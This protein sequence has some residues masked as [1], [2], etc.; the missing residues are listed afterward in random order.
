MVNRKE[1]IENCIRETPDVELLNINMDDHTVTGRLSIKL[2]VM[3]SPLS[4][5]FSIAFTYPF[6][7]HETESILFFNSDL[8]EYSHVMRNG[9]IC[10]HTTSNPDLKDKLNIDLASLK[11]WIL[12]YY[13]NKDKDDHYEHLVV[14]ENPLKGKLQTFIFT[15]CEVPFKPGD[16]GFVNL[17]LI[18][19]G[20]L[21]KVND[22]N[23]VINHL[24]KEF[25]SYDK[26]IR[27]CQWSTIYQHEKATEGGFYCFS[28]QPPSEYQRFIVS[29]WQQLSSILPLELLNQLHKMEK[30]LLKNKQKGIIPLF[31]GY[32][33]NND[34][35]HWQIALFQVGNFPFVGEPEY[36]NEKKTG[37]WNTKILDSPID[38]GIAR[39]SS[40]EYFFG[41]GR[42]CEK[43]TESK[44]L[45]I[46]I[47]AVGS[48]HARTLVRC[49]C[50]NIH[51]VDYD[52]KE[53]EN[54]CRSEYEFRNGITD[55]V[56]ELSTILCKISPFVNISIGNNTMFDVLTKAQ[57]GTDFS[58][59]EIT[60]ILN[61]Y[62]FVFDCSTDNDLLYILDGLQLK[63]CL[64][65]LSITNHAEELV[66][67]IYPN[68]FR[69]VNNQ[70]GNV[71]ENDTSDLY[72]PTGCWAPTFK[73]SYN[74]I[75]L[76]VQMAL[77]H[78]N[79]TLSSDKRL[80]SFVVKEEIDLGQLKIISY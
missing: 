78:I 26:T 20:E 31:I 2:D 44:I 13:I 25:V 60:D 69:F 80:H 50:K 74:D 35:V 53:P 54:V 76:M 73:G 6:K 65:S 39:N 71:L 32:N 22:S 34:E 37:N 63:T 30:K 15:G 38:W 33:I 28:P 24:V 79:R 23:P 67:G 55:K 52:R 57:T 77:K 14:P 16:F 45:I 41:R 8:L 75:S 36:I 3:E 70:F 17:H 42:F 10:I 72:N 59:S 47:G 46:G 66:C 27:K 58:K 5:E 11:A 9:L 62:D 19:E 64:I 48:I 51:L 29:N 4:F 7:V 68:L 56:H 40:Y 43:L 49:G 21:G 18:Q 12:K 61:E 1:L